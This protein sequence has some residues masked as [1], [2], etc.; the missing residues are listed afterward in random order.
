M[1]IPDRAA[2]H[3]RLFE[4]FSRSERY[5]FAGLDMNGLAGRWIA[6]LARCTL[7]HHE[8][9]EAADTDAVT[10]LEV[11]G[12]QPDQ[13]AEHGFGLLLRQFVR[14]REIGGKVFQG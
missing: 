7:A 13:P 12:D 4:F 9:A 8:N 2:L 1:V 6:P 3:D 10:F 14:F 5:L 11:L